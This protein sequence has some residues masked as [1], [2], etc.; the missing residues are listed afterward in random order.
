M[1]DFGISGVERRCQALTLA[2]DIRLIIYLYESSENT[3]CVIIR[4]KIIVADFKI[5]FFVKICPERCHLD[6]LKATHSATNFPFTRKYLN[7]VIFVSSGYQQ[8]E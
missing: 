3:C 1:T 8:A 5:N 6:G 7:L 4:L 2:Y